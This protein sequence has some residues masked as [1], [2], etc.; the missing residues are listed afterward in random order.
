MISVNVLQRF[1]LISGRYAWASL[2]TNGP[3]DRRHLTDSDGPVELSRN[4]GN[5][6]VGLA[7]RGE[8][9]CFRRSHLD[10]LVGPV[11]S[12]QINESHPAGL[13][14][15]VKPTAKLTCKDL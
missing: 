13:S 2:K 7:G 9:S 6:L 4:R 11:E 12:S 10:S 14:N 3:G 8:W 1:A 5:Y 15:P